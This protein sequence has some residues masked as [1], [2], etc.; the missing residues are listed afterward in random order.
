MKVH[1]SNYGTVRKDEAALQEVIAEYGPVSVGI[2]AGRSFQV[3]RI[4]LHVCHCV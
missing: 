2:H 3:C 1:C 4:M